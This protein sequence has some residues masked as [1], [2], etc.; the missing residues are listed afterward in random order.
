MTTSPR[1]GICRNCNED[2][3]HC[4]CYEFNPAQEPKV[5]PA[6]G[7]LAYY[8]HYGEPKRDAPTVCPKCKRLVDFCDH[9]EVAAT[10][11][12]E[13]TPAE[14]AICPQCG[15]R[16]PRVRLPI[17]PDECPCHPDN[18]PKPAADERPARTWT[19]RYY[20]DENDGKPFV[21]Q[22]TGEPYE[23]KHMDEIHVREVKGE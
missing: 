12:A 14:P 9:P 16:R 18:D 1:S 7:E 6:P 17:A 2:G 15:R 10:Q 23:F 21:V 5:A 11:L 4:T 13:P 3:L 22:E 20:A 19:I 8:E